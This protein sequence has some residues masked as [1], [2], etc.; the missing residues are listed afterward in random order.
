MEDSLPRGRQDSRATGLGWLVA[1]ACV[2]MVWNSILLPRTALDMRGGL[3]G[4]HS[5]LGLIVVIL[6]SLRLWWWLRGPHPRPPAGLPESSYA[7]NR[8]ILVALLLTFAVTGLI[9]FPYAWADGQEISLFGLHLPRLVG[10]SRELRGSLGYLHSALA[11]YYLMLFGIW[12]VFGCYQQVR[13]K[14]GMLRLLPGSRV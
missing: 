2:A 11:F 7:F 8:A 9:G 5:T 12:L 10:T 4:I 6:V 13:Y 1:I 14:S 3:R